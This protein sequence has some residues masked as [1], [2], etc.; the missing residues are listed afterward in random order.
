MISPSVSIDDARG[1]PK[2]R[3]YFIINAKAHV[4]LGHPVDKVGPSDVILPIVP[5]FFSEPIGRVE[6]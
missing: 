6:S 2:V 3:V 1:E 4:E 5:P